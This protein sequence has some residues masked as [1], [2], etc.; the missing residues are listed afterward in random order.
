MPAWTQQYIKPGTG[1]R[2]SFQLIF[3]HVTTAITV[4]G[5]NPLNFE[6]FLGYQTNRYLCS[7]RTRVQSYR[8][9][10][11]GK[12]N[13]TVLHTVPGT[14]NCFR[15]A[16]YRVCITPGYLVLTW[17]PTREWYLNVA[18]IFLNKRSILLYPK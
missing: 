13:S 7:F 14:R 4:T 18:V 17:Y 5:M 10:V 16:E 1:T 3:R 2:Y 6:F 8:Y 12:S 15:P 9:L 11:P